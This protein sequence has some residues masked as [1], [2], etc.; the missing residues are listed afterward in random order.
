[1][2]YRHGLP[3]RGFEDPVWAGGPRPRG[4][5]VSWSRRGVVTVVPTGGIVAPPVDGSNFQYTG[6]GHSTSSWFVLSSVSRCGW[7]PSS[8]VSRHA[9]WP[10][11]QGQMALDPYPQFQEVPNIMCCDGPVA[12]MSTELSYLCAAHSKIP[13]RVARCSGAPFLRHCL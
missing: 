13:P 6:L 3:A 8:A 10:G 9:P 5:A 4:A 11:P 7:V 1:M 12:P 2:S